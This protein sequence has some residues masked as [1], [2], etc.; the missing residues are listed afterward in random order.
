MRGIKEEKEGQKCKETIENIPAFEM[1][2]IPAL[3]STM[4]RCHKSEA[5]HREA[6]HIS[7]RHSLFRHHFSFMASLQGQDKFSPL[8]S[9]AQVG[10]ETP[11]QQN[12]CCI[13]CRNG[14]LEKGN[15]K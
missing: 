13:I 5:Q 2:H 7:P 9:K 4:H 14:P 6:F 12:N 8:T 11:T 15:M 10:N 3:Y 1:I